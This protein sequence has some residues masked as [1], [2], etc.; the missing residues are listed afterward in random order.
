MHSTEQLFAIQNEIYNKIQLAEPK[1]IQIKEKAVPLMEKWQEF[2][3]IILPIQLGVIKNHNFEANQLGLSKFNE[4]YSRCSLNSTPLRELT[5]QKWLFMFDKAFGVTEFKEISLQEAQNLVSEIVT[6]MTSDSFLAQIDN[7][8]N[9]L[10]SEASLI[11]KRQAVL[12]LLLP[13]H[14]SVMARHGFAGETGYIQAQRAIMDY[15]HDPLI[16]QKTVYA[17][18]IVFKRAQLI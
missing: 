7:L 8:I 9:S 2:L 12:T 3:E 4:E 16:A 6:E 15:Y 11:E 17:Q 14:M 18:T 13:L 5:A 1:L 10:H